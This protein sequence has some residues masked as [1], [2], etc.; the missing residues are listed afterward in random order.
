MRHAE[1][2]IISPRDCV[3]LKAGPRK[4]DL[5]FVAKVAALWEDEDGEM[6]MSLLWYYR[7]EHTDQG[8]RPAD[9]PDEVFASRHKDTNSV[10]CIE[11]KCYVLTFNEYCRSVLSLYIHIYSVSC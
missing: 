3:L 5:P 10:A 2:D 4:I 8:R 6:M 1:G 11:D 7:P 9:R